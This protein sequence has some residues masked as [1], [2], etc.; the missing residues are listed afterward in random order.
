MAWESLG[1]LTSNN[2]VQF[3]TFGVKDYDS[4]ATNIPIDGLWH[5]LVLVLDSTNTANFYLD[6]QLTDAMTPTLFFH[7][8]ETLAR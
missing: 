8:G 7:S 4:A 5:H 3:T 1:L 2:N 6:G